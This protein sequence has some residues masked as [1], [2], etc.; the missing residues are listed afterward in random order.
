[1]KLGSTCDS[2]IATDT[3]E[4]IET[5]KKEIKED[6]DCY[7][8][9]LEFPPMATSSTVKIEGN[10][11]LSSVGSSVTIKAESS[12]DEIPVCGVVVKTEKPDDFL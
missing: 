10:S 2:S 1:M 3:K 5:C 4:A 8:Y 6:M 9:D 12:D 7:D 11:E